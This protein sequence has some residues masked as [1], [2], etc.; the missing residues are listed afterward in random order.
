MSATK[1]ND[2]SGSVTLAT[3]GPTANYTVYLPNSNGTIMFDAGK[4]LTSDG[5]Q[6]LSNGLIMQWGRYNESASGTQTFPQTFP[7]ACFG[8]Y[9]AV[10]YDSN[11][12]TSN[13]TINSITT[14]SFYQYLSAATYSTYWF[15]IGY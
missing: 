11:N 2:A 4:S 7:N 10:Q 12:S 13:Q 14:S 3:N 9:N 5:Y 6:K 1:F 15:A 8:V